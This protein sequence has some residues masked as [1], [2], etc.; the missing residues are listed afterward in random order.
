MAA[1]SQLFVRGL[2]SSFS[3]VI[4]SVLVGKLV[5]VRGFVG[6]ALARCWSRCPLIIALK[7]GGCFRTWA[8]VSA[9]QAV[10]CLALM[11]LHQVERA[12]KNS[13]AWQKAIC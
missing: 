4:C 1:G 10:A 5:M 13:E 12:G 11:A 3:L 8:V 9:G 2:R 7:T 6:R